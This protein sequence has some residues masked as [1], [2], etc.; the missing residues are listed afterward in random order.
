VRV[1]M[2]RVSEASVSVDGATVG[3][4]AQGWLVLVGVRGDDSDEDLAYILDKTVNLRAFPDAEGKMNLSV[5][6]VGGAML[7]VSQF[8]LYGDT[9]KG[10]RPGFSDAAPP[11]KA[12]A[13]YERYVAE[14]RKTG[15]SVA[16]GQFQSH[17]QV[18]LVNDG[19]VT[20]ML[21]SRK[22]F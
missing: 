20:F 14:L 15:L 9:R 2:Q 5:L 4:I 8:T 21:D 16:T 12:N 3:A 1:V 19:P 18:K 6:D 10:R 13:M 11:E 17:M 7:I 22:A